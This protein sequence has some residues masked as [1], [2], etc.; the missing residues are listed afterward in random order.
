MQTNSFLIGESM[1]MS[2]KQLQRRQHTPSRAARKAAAASSARG[3][4]ASGAG[5]PAALPPG[6][7]VSRPTRSSLAAGRIAG[8]ISLLQDLELDSSSVAPRIAAHGSSLPAEQHSMCSVRMQCV[9]KTG[10]HEAH[11]PSRFW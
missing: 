10:L 2:H 8:N 3:P 6:P 1:P 7:A 4:A 5:L 9:S 11:A